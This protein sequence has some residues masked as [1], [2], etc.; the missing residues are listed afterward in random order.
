MRYQVT[1]KSI[2]NS[3]FAVVRVGYCKLTHLLAFQETA[4]YTAGKCG[5]KSDV[6]TIGN[7]AISTG[8]QPFG[9]V[10]AG[11]EIC[12]KWDDQ[13]RRVLVST[14]PENV[15]RHK[16]NILLNGFITEALRGE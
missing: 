11:V 13:A 15:K 12:S 5:W 8:Y 3:H 9:N 16:I 6:Y 7:V 4:A 14:D 10:R 2:V 1:Q